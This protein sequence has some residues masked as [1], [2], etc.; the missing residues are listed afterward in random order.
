[1]EINQ[2]KVCHLNNQ[3]TCD[4]SHLNTLGALGGVCL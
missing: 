1:M 4:V 2:A 3:D